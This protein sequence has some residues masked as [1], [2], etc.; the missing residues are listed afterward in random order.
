MNEQLYGLTRDNLLRT[1]PEALARDEGMQPIAYMA[2]DAVAALKPHTQL[3]KIYARI[4]ELDE[5]VLDLLARDFKVEWYDY[6]YQLSTK[7]ALIRDSFFVHRHLG[8]KGSVVS[9]MSDVFPQS[10]IQEW[11]EYGG[12]PY[13]FRVIIDVTN[14]AEQAP[15]GLIKKKINF[16]K[17]AR[18][19]LQDDNIIARI[20]CGIAI[21][22]S[23]GG[24]GYATPRTGT[25][26]A[27][28]TQGGI[29]DSLLSAAALAAGSLYRVPMCGTALNALM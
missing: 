23:V 1:L 18:S 16:Y 19:H 28:S 24:I 12:Q 26:P 11:W 27:V 25:I 17:S 21:N 5:Q 15:L 3:V 2:A 29:D 10:S 8:T 14:T 22:S 9:A 20:S 7:R 4:D 6:N 13:Y